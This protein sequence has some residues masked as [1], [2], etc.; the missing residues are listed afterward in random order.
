MRKTQ[1]LI[2]EDEDFFSRNVRDILEDLGYGIAGIESSGEKALEK[3]RE[4][5]PDL[6]LMDIMLEGGMDGVEAAEEIRKRLNIPVVYLTGLTGD[7]LLERAKTTEPFGYILKPFQERELHT[8]IE[9]ALYRHNLEK[10]LRE[11]EGKVN[12][13]LESICDHMYMVDR[14]L[15]VIWTNEKANGIFGSQV[16]GRKCCNILHSKNEPCISKET[17][18]K[19]KISHFETE[20]KNVN[21][22]K[23]YLSWCSNIAIRDKE[24]VPL[25]ILAI[26]RDITGQRNL[27]DKL[28]ERLSELERLNQLMVGRELKME[29]M[30]NELRGLKLKFKKV[31]Q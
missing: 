14:E 11:S 20:M 17:F 3:A 24:G 9:I 25:T 12:A 4:I 23:V 13:I 21:G 7:Q 8:V 19:G 18:D 22:E 10:K 26:A 29:E 1:I 30:R 5:C 28:N 31:E 16:L 6:V 15:K 27:Q 2:V